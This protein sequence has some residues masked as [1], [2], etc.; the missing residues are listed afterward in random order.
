MK[1]ELKLWIDA[2]VWDGQDR[3]GCKGD[4][5]KFTPDELQELVDDLFDDVMQAKYAAVCAELEEL[6]E[7]HINLW[8]DHGKQAKEVLCYIDDIELRDKEIAALKDMVSDLKG[9]V[10]DMEIEKKIFDDSIPKLKA[11]AFKSGFMVSGEGYNGELY[12][13]GWENCIS[14][15]PFDLKH[16]LE[17]SK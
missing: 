16:Y 7:K 1:A 9:E 6:T 14:G 3:A 13:D 2:N 12:Q 8:N 4:F 11:D 17:Q 5:A 15:L 10:A